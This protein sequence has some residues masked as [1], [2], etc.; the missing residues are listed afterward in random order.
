MTRNAQNGT[1][2][3]VDDNLDVRAFAEVFLEH[4]GYSVV[5]AA[6]GKEGLRYYQTHQS[7]YCALVN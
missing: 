1:I 2:L 4:A 5:T 7:E 6:D 3:I